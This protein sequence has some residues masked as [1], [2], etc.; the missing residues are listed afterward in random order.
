[1]EELFHS[2][3][4]LSVILPLTCFFIKSFLKDSY[5]KFLNVY[6]HPLKR[7]IDRGREEEKEREDPLFSGL[8]PKLTRPP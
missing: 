2:V 4:L 3:S 6:F 1:M 8:L 7:Q 5:E